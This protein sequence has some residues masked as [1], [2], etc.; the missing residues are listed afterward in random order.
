MFVKWKKNEGDNIWDGD[1][2]RVV[3]M[4]SWRGMGAQYL[5][6]VEGVRRE[7]PLGG[8]AESSGLIMS[9]SRTAC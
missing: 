3:R 9:S 8:R 2:N 6:K 5:Q 1:P 4:R 7:G